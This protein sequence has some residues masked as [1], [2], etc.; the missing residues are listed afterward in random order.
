LTSTGYEAK[1]LPV[2]GG[3]DILDI[4]RRAERFVTADDCRVTGIW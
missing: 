1:S 4:D 2:P 3:N